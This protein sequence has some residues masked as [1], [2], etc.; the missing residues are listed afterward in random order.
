MCL[1]DPGSWDVLAKGVLSRF[2]APRPAENS[3]I[4]PRKGG[5]D[6]FSHQI[7]LWELGKLFFIGAPYCELCQIIF[8]F[9]EVHVY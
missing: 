7:R 1:V 2:F 3:G 6:R 8:R 5:A 9:C 4:L